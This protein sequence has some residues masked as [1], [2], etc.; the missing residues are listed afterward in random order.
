MRSILSEQ[1]TTSIRTTG[2]SI[3]LRRES[4]RG[5]TAGYNRITIFGKFEAVTS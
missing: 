2:I 5:L 3:L 1:L 4:L